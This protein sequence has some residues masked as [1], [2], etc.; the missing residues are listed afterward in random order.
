MMRSL[1]LDKY[2]ILLIEGKELFW[3]LFDWG[4]KW[5]Y[6]FNPAGVGG[7]GVDDLPRAMPGATNIK[8]LWG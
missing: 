3:N 4:R 7:F 2:K 5:G 8:P 6:L 1:I